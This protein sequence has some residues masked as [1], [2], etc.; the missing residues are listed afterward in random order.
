M[1]SPAFALATALTNAPEVETWNVVPA[2]LGWGAAP[3]RA[4]AASGRRETRRGVMV[5]WIDPPA[6][7]YVTRMVEF[8]PSSP[9]LR[10]SYRQI[11]GSPRLRQGRRAR[12]A[13]ASR[14]PPL[15]T[16]EGHGDVAVA[17]ARRSARGST[18]PRHR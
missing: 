9:V 8:C 1:V 4:A 14:R 7:L 6:R 18:R 16:G 11:R 12:P 3:V 5:K 17:A 10:S 15:R 2:G 13:A